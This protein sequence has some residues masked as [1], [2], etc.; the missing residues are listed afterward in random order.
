[1]RHMNKIAKIIFIF[2]LLLILNGINHEILNK[3]PFGINLTF[4]W[5]G[6]CGVHGNIGFP[7][8]V[9]SPHNPETN[10]LDSYN[11]I[12]KTLNFIFLVLLTYGI[13]FFIKN[14][15]VKKR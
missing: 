1:M 8:S 15:I 6:G 2:A 4:G 3:I 12:G 9:I 14:I 10:C 5:S 11:P 7:F 13:Y